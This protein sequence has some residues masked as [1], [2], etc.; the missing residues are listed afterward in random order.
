MLHV[1][2][3]FRERII[4]VQVAGSCRVGCGCRHLETHSLESSCLC[5]CATS[6]VLSSDFGIAAKLKA[7]LRTALSVHNMKLQL[8][9]GGMASWA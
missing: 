2:K 9:A 8:V 3:A 4:K 5:T 1:C 7:V 6:F